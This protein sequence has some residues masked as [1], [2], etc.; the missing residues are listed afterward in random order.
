MPLVIRRRRRHP[1]RLSLLD[2]GL[3][4]RTTSR[5]H[6]S[7]LA[8][9]APDR[10]SLTYTNRDASARL[11]VDH[12]C[13]SASK[14]QQRPVLQRDTAGSC[15]IR[16]SPSRHCQSRNART[17]GHFALGAAGIEASVAAAKTAAA[18]SGLTGHLHLHANGQL[19]LSGLVRRNQIN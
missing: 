6:R 12:R 11:G 3:Q 18:R 17:K 15:K 1:K 10:C 4:T 14:I 7:R 13:C 9:R 2:A 19:R 8:V 16:N 5:H